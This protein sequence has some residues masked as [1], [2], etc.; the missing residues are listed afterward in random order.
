[1]TLL[2]TLLQ[3]RD[4]LDRGEFPGAYGICRYVFLGTPNLWI[5]ESWHL[6]ELFAEWPEGTGLELYPIPGHDK[7]PY[8]PSAEHATPEH[9]WDRSQPYGAARYRLLNYLIEELSK[10]NQHG[11]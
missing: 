4:E 8:W 2:E 5:F 6:K 10:T 9:F 7:N 11:I 1:M 3:L